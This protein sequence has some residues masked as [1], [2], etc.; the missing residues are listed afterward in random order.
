[1]V[2]GADDQSVT[3]WDLQET[4]Q[5]HPEGHR[6]WVTALGISADGSRAISGSDDEKLIVWDAATGNPVGSLRKIEHANA[7]GQTAP[8]RLQ[9]GAATPPHGSLGDSRGSK[10]M[11]TSVAALTRDGRRAIT[12]GW[13]LVAMIWNLETT[14]L[15]GHF[16]HGRLF[17]A[18]AL[19]LDGEHAILAH[20]NTLSVWKLEYHQI[21]DT[22]EVSFGE[23][24]TSLQ[25]PA[26]DLM[27]AAITSVRGLAVT[28]AESG[29][30]TLWDLVRRT[31]I[32]SGASHLATIGA[33]ALSADGRRVLTGSWDTTLKL[34]DSKTGE[35]LRMFVGHR[36]P[37]SGVAFLEDE[38]LVVSASYDRSVVIWD[39]RTGA[40]VSRLITRLAVFSL[41]AA[42]NRLL[43]G[44]A[45]GS[46]HFLEVLGVHPNTRTR[47]ADKNG[48]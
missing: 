14:S 36:L 2:T 27:S 13:D 11:R 7:D 23:L 8:S 41:A 43:V 17:A 33:V 38:N 24:E 25:D 18:G 37:V 42:G 9:A 44:D 22:S 30:M 4:R 39:V 26:G 15:L 31:V 28:G 40:S 29:G 34:W 1:L 19:S 5:H 45:E 6:N 35:E 46:V 21:G 12:A 32:R 20:D 47:F 48:V 10:A 16:A 3:L